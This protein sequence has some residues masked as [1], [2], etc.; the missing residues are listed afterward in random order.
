MKFLRARIFRRIF[1]REKNQSRTRA[2]TSGLTPLRE[3]RVLPPPRAETQV[4]WDCQF[5]DQSLPLVIIEKGYVQRKIQAGSIEPS[6]M[7]FYQCCGSGIW[8]LFDPWI[9]DPGWVKKSGSGSGIRD[10]QPWSYFLELRNHFFVLKYFDADPGSE[11]QNGNNSDPGSGI[12]T[13][14]Y[15]TDP[16]HFGRDPAIFVSS[17]TFKTAKKIPKVFLLIRVLFEGT[18]T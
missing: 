5:F 16:W 3:G 13:A 15:I 1:P 12:N 7:P 6:A 14:S 4:G 11:I 17:V 2:I 18:F 8:C 9:R 10:E